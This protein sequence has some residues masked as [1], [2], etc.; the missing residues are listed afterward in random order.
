MG[1][2]E[3]LVVH[4]LQWGEHTQLP[5]GYWRTTWTIQLESLNGAQVKDVEVA[6]SDSEAGFTVAIYTNENSVLEIEIETVR[7]AMEDDYHIL[8]YRL[9][10]LIDSRLGR[11]LLLQ[12]SP[13]DWWPPFMP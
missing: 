11:I 4:P 10:R 8:T 6:A 12:G 2:S 3:D 9:F 7:R 1:D 13:R 5:S